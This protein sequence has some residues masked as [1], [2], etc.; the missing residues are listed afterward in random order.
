MSLEL[1]RGVNESGMT[2]SWFIDFDDTL[3]T[4][5]TTWGLKYA[6]PR[7]VQLNRLPFDKEHFAHAVL[8]AQER[9]AG[10]SDIRP[11]LDELFDG[12]GWPHS[13]QQQLVDDLRTGYKPELFN[14]VLPFLQRLANSHKSVYVISNNPHA[15]ELAQWL[16]IAQFILKYFTP[17][18]CPGALPK[19]NASLWS[20][21]LASGIRADNTNSIMIGDDPWSDGVF[22]D[23]C[24]LS[25]WI[26]DRVDRF[27]NGRYT[28]KSYKWTQSL[29]DIPI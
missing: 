13:L 25:C 1:E 28:E 24:G 16:G 3:A 26:I 15:P 17:K 4:G 7:L 27:N 10:S 6:L 9:V 8:V 18:T 19:P 20:Y 2:K 21:V 11:A 14:D 5:P 12:M 23:K 22:A 29:L